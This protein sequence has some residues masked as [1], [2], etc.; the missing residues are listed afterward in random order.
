MAM[1]GPGAGHF[2]DSLDMGEVDLAEIAFGE[3]DGPA[4]QPACQG[5]RGAGQVGGRQDLRARWCLLI[6]LGRPVSLFVLGQGG[7][8]GQGG[9]QAGVEVLPKGGQDL[10]AEAI[11]GVGA[12]L[13]G[14]VLA[15]S[16]IAGAEPAFDLAAVEVQK[17]PDNSLLTYRQN[18]GEA[19]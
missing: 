9:V 15:P 14:F 18:S 12:I 19:G 5:D 10:V 16:D 2:E 7:H 3:L 17:G 8:V 4:D 6:E 11:S 1:A 13:V